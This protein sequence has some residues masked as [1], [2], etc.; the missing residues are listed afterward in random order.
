VDSLRYWVEEMHVDGFRFDLAAILGRDESGQ[1]MPNPL[2]CGT[3]NRTRRSLDQ[4]HCRG[5]DAAGL[6]EV[7]SFIGDSWEGV[8]RKFRD[9][10]RSFFSWGRGICG[11]VC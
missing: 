3:L 4:A 6:Y 11:T 1:S 9:D 10:V 5:L 8:E 2:Y 7:G